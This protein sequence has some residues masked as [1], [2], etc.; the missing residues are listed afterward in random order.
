MTSPRLIPTAWTSSRLRMLARPRRC[1]R[2][3]P[4]VSYMCAK[5]RSLRLVCAGAA[6]ACSPS[7][8]STPSSCVCGRSAA[9]APGL[10][11]PYLALSAVA[12]RLFRGA[13][14]GAGRLPGAWQIHCPC[15]STSAMGW[16]RRRPTTPRFRGPGGCTGYRPTEGCFGEC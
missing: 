11:P 1:S 2:L 9:V 4:P 16:T 7:P 6:C 14:L 10:A 3:M 5:L 12:D 13:R 15:A 8:G